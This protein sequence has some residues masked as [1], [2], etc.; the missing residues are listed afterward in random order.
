MRKLLPARQYPARYLHT[1]FAEIFHNFS[2]V[3]F[4]IMFS[5][6]MPKSGRPSL[7]LSKGFALFARR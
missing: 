5:G 6:A 7:L 3:F 1:G 2:K 4:P